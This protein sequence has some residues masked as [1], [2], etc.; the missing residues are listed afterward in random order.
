MNACEW[1]EPR[2]AK[3][4][5][6]VLQLARSLHTAF[7]TWWAPSMFSSSLVLGQTRPKVVVPGETSSNKFQWDQAQELQS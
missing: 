1:I 3:E 4:L 2:R 6:L 5:K 7:I